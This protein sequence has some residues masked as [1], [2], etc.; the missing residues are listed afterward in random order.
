MLNAIVRAKRALMT[1]AVG[2]AL[3]GIF[4]YAHAEENSRTLTFYNIH[5]KETLA[6][7]YKRDGEF[8]PEGMKQINHIMRDWRRDESTK[9]D[10]KLIDTIWEIYQELGSEK[11]IHLISGYRSKK[12][13][14]RLRRRRGGQARKSQHI[15]GK[16]ADIHFPDVD[17]KRLR[18]SA[19]VREAGG[20][21][22]YPKSGIPF[23][24]VDTGRV[25]HWPRLPRQELAL[26][27]PEGKSKHVPRDGRPITP[28]DS[29]IALAKL[30]K[31]I[32]D[33]IIKKSKV[34]VPPK[35]MVAG[36]TPPNLSWQKA[37]PETTASIPKESAPLPPA[38][39]TAA[40][41]PAA[42]LPAPV[43]TPAAA[44]PRFAITALDEAEH[45]EELT[46]ELAPLLPLM[47]DRL[48]SSDR[49]LARLTAPAFDGDD[50]YLL[51]DADDGY[52]VSLARAL[53]YS[54][55]AYRAALSS[56]QP[57]RRQA[58]AVNRAFVQTA[59]YAETTPD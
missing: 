21:G 4:V 19:L 24:H 38:E 15:L 53:G 30:G 55:P 9:M 42:P 17:V 31:R 49:H 44:S 22:Y 48:V 54:G 52:S 43:Q 59:R 29:R 7:T 41:E 2:L 58:T 10:P 6:I 8:D 33:F 39:K 20:V 51:R 11:P 1:G 32:D 57:T 28:K 37:S 13:N 16:A 14:E 26:L 27:F 56:D 23:V 40:L 47:G 25:R 12:T 46:F 36:F 3:S 45:P 5:T 35:M 34:K 18:N 50:G